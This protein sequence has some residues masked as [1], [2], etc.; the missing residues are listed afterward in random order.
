[1]RDIAISIPPYLKGT[2]D[3][4]TLAKAED[5]AATARRDGTAA[6]KQKIATGQANLLDIVLEVTHEVL[7]PKHDAMLRGLMAPKPEQ[8]P[9]HVECRAGC[10]FCCHQNVEVTIPEAILVANAIRGPIDPRHAIL[11]DTATATASLTQHDRMKTGRACPLLVDDDCSVYADRP[12]LCRALLSSDAKRCETAFR[13]VVTES[14]D[15][16]V[17]FYAL[18][19][20]FSRACQAGLQGVCKDLGLQHDTVDLVQAVA[21]ILRDSGLLRRWAAGE[22][23]FDP[24]HR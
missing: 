18:P 3:E 10:S 7:F 16:S 14:G 24:A 9:P 20:L 11:L 15:I 8:A 12:M 1:M 21:A 17:I 2:L 22:T 6:A 5:V 23:V 13:N 4:I 19:Q